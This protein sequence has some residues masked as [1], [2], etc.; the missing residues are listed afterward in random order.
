LLLAST[1]AAALKRLT[2]FAMRRAAE[3]PAAL[4]AEAL[5]FAGAFTAVFF[6]GLRAALAGLGLAFAAG[7]AAALAAGFAA[8]FAAGLAAAVRRAVF[9]AGLAGAFALGVAD[10]ERAR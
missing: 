7:F 9:A 1:G 5:A 6:T 2:A 10:P 4:L 3:E 8:A